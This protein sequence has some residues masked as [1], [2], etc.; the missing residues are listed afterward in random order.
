[1]VPGPF[2]SGTAFDIRTARPMLPGLLLLL[3]AAGVLPDPGLLSEVLTVVELPPASLHLELDLAARPDDG[4][5]ELGRT[6][7]RGIPLGDLRV[8]P[9]GV[10]GAPFLSNFLHAHEIRFVE[11]DPE[12]ALSSLMIQLRVDLD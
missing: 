3:A 7:G 12:A 6:L 4:M 5:D 9:E 10:P 1:M 11:L 2:D 8:G